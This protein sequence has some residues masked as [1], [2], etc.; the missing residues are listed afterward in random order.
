MRRILGNSIAER[1]AHYNIETIGHI[2][3]D[4]ISELSEIVAKQGQRLMPGS[5]RDDLM[6]ELGKE[7]GLRLAIAIVPDREEDQ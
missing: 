3:E 7:K 6:F 4:T 5:Q 2:S 1:N